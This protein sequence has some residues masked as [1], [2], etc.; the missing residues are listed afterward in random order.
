MNIV[1][2]LIVRK[3]FHMFAR[4]ISIYHCRTL[5]GANVAPA[6]EVHMSAMLLLQIVGSYKV[7][8]FVA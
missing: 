4:Y 3:I 6:L 2:F 5:S 8:L 1:Y 7:S